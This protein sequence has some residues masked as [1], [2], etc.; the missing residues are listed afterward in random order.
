MDARSYC[1]G[2][3]DHRKG[4]AH[5]KD[6]SNDLA[7]AQKALEWGSKDL[8]ELRL[9][10]DGMIGAVHEHR[11]LTPVDLLRCAVIGP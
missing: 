1:P 6:E 2:I 7:Q 3:V 5:Q 9:C 4:T 10:V 11:S 8:E